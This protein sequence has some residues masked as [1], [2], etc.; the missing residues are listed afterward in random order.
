M[1]QR[2]NGLSPRARV[3]ADI[4]AVA[5]DRCTYELLRVA[6]GHSSETLTRAVRGLVDRFI[7]AEVREAGAERVAFRH[8]LTREAVYDRLLEPERR[9]LHRSVGF[10][11]L[12]T[13]GGSDPAVAADLGRHFHAARAWPET[14][15]YAGRAGMAATGSHATAESLIHFRRALDAA[16]A[17]GHTERGAFH[18]RCGEAYARLGAF[19]Q[20]RQQWEAA[21]A[22]ARGR[23][24]AGA[25]IDAL[26]DL[27]RLHGSRD[28]GVAERLA[29]EALAHAIEIGD[30]RRRGVALNRLGN[31]LTNLGRFGEGRAMHE[32]ASR[33]FVALGDERGAAA[34]VDLTAMAWYLAGDVRLAR[35][36]FGEAAARFAALDDVEGMASA[37]TSRGLYLAVIDGPCTTEAPPG[38]YRSDAAEGL[39]LCREIGWRS[40]EIY[41]LVALATVALGAGE[42]G[43]AGEQADAA[44]RLA[45]EDGHAQ[46]TVIALFVLGLRLADLCDDRG[47]LARFEEGQEIAIRLGS[48]QWR[49]RLRA[50]IAWC[51]VRIGDSAAALE[52]LH[53][54]TP[55]DGFGPQSIGQ[56]RACMAMAE[57]RLGAG[58]PEQAVL[59]V[60]RLLDGAA[61]PRPAEAM[62]LRG[63]ILGMTRARIEA[64]AALLEARRLAAAVG[65]RPVLWR[66]AAARSLLWAGNDRAVAAGEA[67]IA[68]EELSRLAATIP[69]EAEREAFRAA[70]EVRR[71]L[72]AAGR[73]RTADAAAPGGLTRRERAVAGA[74]ATGLANKEI[75]RVMGIADKTVEMHVG[76][77]LGKLGFSSRSQLAV[78]AVEQG[79]PRTDG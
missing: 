30:D 67:D 45:A 41:A 31:V 65:P 74:V 51:R 46:W 76:T 70:P 64:D 23:E 66:V 24:D 34:A 15:V 35:A 78:W 1:R 53:G 48:V 36:A 72:A 40:G 17:L 63:R 2:L 77:C 79:I 8:A 29:R 26:D 19:D 5:G 59:W 55:A 14:L 25:E 3:I 39:R 69:M 6:S 13:A 32:A 54:I 73:R 38:D 68:R 4:A 71:W 10:A 37:R 16:I 18:R 52:T 9:G 43:L 22:V 60:G 57:L 12:E 58:D 47:A 62:L 7:M 27:A 50:W 49:E 56:R 11:L 20:A 28:Y 21:L 75:A 44:H 33:F 61:G 42:Y